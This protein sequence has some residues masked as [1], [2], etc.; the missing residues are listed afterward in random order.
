[1]NGAH[2]L[3]QV[4]PGVQCF[5]GDEARRRRSIEA[6]IVSVFEGWDYEEII[7]PLFDYADVF[8]GF[9]LGSKMYSFLGRDGSLLALRPDFTSLLAKIVAGRLATRPPPIRLYYSGEV[10]RYEPPKAG[11]QSELHQIGLERLGGEARSADAE[12][13]AIAA[14]CLEALGVRGFVLTLGHV[15]VFA[16]LV[17][18]KG[19]DA[20]A[21]AL[22]RD[23]VEGRDASGV[24]EVLEGAGIQGEPAEALVRLATL[25]SGPS[26]LDEAAG[27]FAFCGAAAS[28][29]NELRGVVA[30]LVEAGFGAHLAIDLGEVRG[31]D[32]YTGLVFR[33]Y[34]PGLGFDVGGGGRYD[35]LLARFGRPLPAVGFM[36]GLDRVALLLDRQGAQPSLRSLPAER[37]GE[38]EPLGAALAHARERRAAGIRV[39][40]GSGESA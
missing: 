24:R 36:L 6:R 16:G 25:G 19:L 32:Y 3:V 18:A 11:R 13:L 40:F 10:L 12:V 26:A 15:G 37:V 27:A 22:L 14:E 4:P 2:R 5:V 38:G 1:M 39:R 17:A 30:A 8:E 33:L 35:A 28:A 31:L 20:T 21:V 9:A 29:L 34:A 23:R 7:P